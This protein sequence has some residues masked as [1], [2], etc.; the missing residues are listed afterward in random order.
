[1]TIWETYKTELFWENFLTVAGFCLGTAAPAE[2]GGG[3]QLR[4]EED[5]ELV[6]WRPLGRANPYVGNE[7]KGKKSCTEYFALW[8]IP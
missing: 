7:I 1:M 4:S 6:A 3:Q 5:L 2:G 8:F